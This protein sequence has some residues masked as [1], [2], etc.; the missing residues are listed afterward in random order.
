MRHVLMSRPVRLVAAAA[1][2]TGGMLVAAL[3]AGAVGHPSGTTSTA[4]KMRVFT[5]YADCPNGPSSCSA[6]AIT[7]P[8]YPRPWYGAGGVTFIADP[9]VVDPTKDSDP[10]TSAIR[11]D[12]T[13]TTDLQIQ[14]LSVT[15]CG[16]NP[17]DLWTASYPVTIPPKGK[18]VFSSTSGDNFDG[19]EIC[20]VGPTVNVEVAGVTYSYADNVADGGRGAIVGV[21]G[22]DEST[23][24]TVIGGARDTVTAW[25]TSLP[26]GKVGT[27]YNSFVGLQGTDGA[28]T[29]SLAAGTL[30]PGLTL[31]TGPQ[32]ADA[33]LAGTPTQAGVYSF[34]VGVTD[35]KGDTGSLNYTVTIGKTTT[36]LTSSANP[37][38]VDTHVTYLAKVNPHPDGGTVQFS[39]DG[40]VIARCA[41]VTVNAA[42]GA[43]CTVAYAKP[44]TRTVVATYQGDTDYAAST[45]APLQETVN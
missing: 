27:A 37:T 14:D 23:P 18:T 9:N 40:S 41:A 20:G 44:G 38:T 13:G 26:N 16:S 15:G 33:T 8:T 28:P 43:R 6:N 17:L 2:L 21:A 35:A 30:P 3:P 19:S 45:S 42:G 1:A 24:W 36:T 7:D 5:G 29:V 39:Q 22:F 12:N 32:P 10:D 34:T 4:P 11:I 31:A 25:P